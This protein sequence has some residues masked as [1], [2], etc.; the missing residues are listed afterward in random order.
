MVKF[1]T[2]QTARNNSDVD[3]MKQLDT[4]N[5]TLNQQN[6]ANSDAGQ[7]IAIANDTLSSNDDE[8]VYLNVSFGKLNNA[9]SALKDSHETFAKS[10]KLDSSNGLSHGQ[11]E[12]QEDSSDEI[13][14]NY[15][16]P[17]SS[18]VE[19]S[20]CNNENGRTFTKHAFINAMLN[21][22]S[23]E[24]VK[25]NDIKS[26]TNKNTPPSCSEADAST[27]E[28]ANEIHNSSEDALL[29]EE[30]NDNLYENI[31]TIREA[32]NKNKTYKVKNGRDHAVG[33]DRVKNGNV[34]HLNGHG[35]HL[36]GNI[37][38]IH[39]LGVSKKDLRIM[40]N[41]HGNQLDGNICDIHNLDVNK[42]DLGRMKNGHATVGNGNHFTGDN[43]VVINERVEKNKDSLDRNER[44]H[45]DVAGVNATVGKVK[46]ARSKSGR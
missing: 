22:V 16:T 3:I 9:T 23:K 37:S 27:S 19:V 12:S 38:D 20:N 10:D 32:M 26:K 29:N 2:D 30:E 18:K 21:K 39:N 8:D 36:D 13:Y 34:N 43:L 33:N 5:N 41:G 14:E 35:N 24:N 28:D 40:K 11:I 7:C 25:F 1:N 31:E 42:K 46:S 44:R 15:T 17:N 45:D 4:N 6:E